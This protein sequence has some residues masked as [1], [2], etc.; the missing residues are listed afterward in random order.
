MKTDPKKGKKLLN[1]L[2]KWRFLNKKSFGFSPSKNA[3]EGNRMKIL[4]Q[5]GTLNMVGWLENNRLN[6][7]FTT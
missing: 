2:G 4:S 7:D 1:Q 6:S 5:N 3:R